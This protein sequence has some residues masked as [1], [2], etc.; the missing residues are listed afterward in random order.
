MSLFYQWRTQKGQSFWNFWG[1]GQKDV[2]EDTIERAKSEGATPVGSPQKWSED[3]R[4]KMT[5]KARGGR[6]GVEMR[7]VMLSS[8]E[9]GDVTTEILTRP[10][11]RSLRRKKI[12]FT[13]ILTSEQL[14]SCW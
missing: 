4:K 2:N 8:D 9:D 13:N 14:V 7:E 6:E 10:R 1:R 5:S 11:Q 12:G 3:N